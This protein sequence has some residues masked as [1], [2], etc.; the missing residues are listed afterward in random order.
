M[1]AIKYSS[2]LF[3]LM[4]STV[5]NASWLSKITGVDVK[6]RSNSS[7][8]EINKPQPEAIGDAIKHF[9]NDLKNFLNPAGTAL[10]IA[11]RDA[12]D[13][14]RPGANRIPAN[15]RNK[16][17][18]YFPASILNRVRWKTR[19]QQG[20][21]LDSIVLKVGDADAITLDDTIVFR[22]GNPAS[23]DIANLELWAHELTHVLQYQNMG[24]ESFANV[25][26]FNWNGLEN[27]SSRAAASIRQ[28]IARGNAQSRYSTNTYNNL[29]DIGTAQIG[30]K[31]FRQFAAQSIPPQNC[32]QWQQIPSGAR[33][34][35]ICNVNMLILSLTKIHPFNGQP[36]NLQCSFECYLA[37][38][39]LITYNSPQPGQLV[40]IGFQFVP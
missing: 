40:N 1:R 7:S 22:M 11:I 29:N 33:I 5:A 10:A 14:V 36:Y 13:N 17:S 19:S 20:F 16:L 25:Y 37:A 9:P 23:E 27:Q 34:R 24:V 26:S 30:A 4:V 39:Q 18:P 32:V 15:I 6:V 31:K 21:G 8:I 3:A 12:R 35:N 38:G 28:D 2:I